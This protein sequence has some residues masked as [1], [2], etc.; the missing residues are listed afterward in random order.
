M[1]SDQDY[2]DFIMDQL[3][4]LPGVSCRKMFGEYAIYIHS[5][6]VALVCDNTLYV[7]PTKAGRL[8]IGTPTEA[9]PYPG[10][11]P[12]FEIRDQVE[13]REWLQ[14]LFTLTDSE[15]PEPKPKA[16]KKAAPK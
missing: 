8:F 14:K 10:A 7:K 5:K 12:S 1:A 4:S 6:V 13:E 16:K 2:V 9:P 3:S 15:L 11:K